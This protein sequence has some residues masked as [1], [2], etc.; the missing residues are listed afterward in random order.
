M[1]KKAMVSFSLLGLQARS[2]AFNPLDVHGPSHKYI[3]PCASLPGNSSPIIPQFFW[4]L[5]FEGSGKIFPV[6]TSWVLFLCFV[7]PTDFRQCVQIL[8]GLQKAHT[9]PGLG[10]SVFQVRADFAQMSNFLRFVFF[11]CHECLVVLSIFCST[12]FSRRFPR[13]HLC[14]FGLV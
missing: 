12:G 2:L 9:F 6:P 1:P 4:F 5:N 8:C 13:F 3:I 14:L 11:F 10:L 7:V